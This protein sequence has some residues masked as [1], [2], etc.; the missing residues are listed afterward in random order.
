MLVK[1]QVDHVEDTLS[2]ADGQEPVYT[3]L[4][5]KGDPKI[6]TVCEQHSDYSLS[7]YFYC[8]KSVCKYVGRK[9]IFSTFF[10]LVENRGVHVEVNSLLP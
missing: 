1:S 3:C 5:N 9:H 7:W 4:V 8:I 10:S 6:L 2:Y